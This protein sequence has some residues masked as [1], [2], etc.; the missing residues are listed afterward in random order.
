MRAVKGMS[1][2]KLIRSALINDSYTY[3][4]VGNKVWP[5]VANDG[6]TF[7]FIVYNRTNLSSPY[8]SKDGWI[9]DN[10]SFSVNVASD[11]YDE[12]CIV[13][14]YARNALENNILSNSYLVLDSI[15][16]I[17]ASESFVE[18]TFIQTMNFDAQA[19]NPDA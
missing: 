17:S 18:D 4:Y 16:L 3:S 10:V 15:R 9:G 13:A 6:T 1:A 5:L 8:N 14:D 12:S 7:P 11:D 19:Y 2:G